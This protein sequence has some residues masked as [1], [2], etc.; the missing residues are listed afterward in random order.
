MGSIDQLDRIG[1]ARKTELIVKDIRFSKYCNIVFDHN[2]YNTRKV[3]LDY[4]TSKN[5][6]P[7]GR[8]GKW[9][10]YW[11]DQSF[12]SGYSAAENNLK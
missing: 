7:I 11:S 6:I 8:F 4:L 5:V 9:E 3:I 1:A 12:I 2:I 10:Y